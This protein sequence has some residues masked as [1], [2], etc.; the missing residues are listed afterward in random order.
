MNQTLVDEKTIARNAWRDSLQDGLYEL[1]SGVGLLFIALLLQSEAMG[2][3]VIVAI[4]MPALV[5]RLKERYTY[6]R[7]GYV[8]FPESSKNFGREMLAALGIAI[9]LIALLI[10]ATGGINESWGWNKWLPLLPA[11]LFQ[12][13]F[14]PLANRSGIKRYYLLAGLA[15]LLGVVFTLPTLPGRTD[16]LSLY[17][18]AIGTVL[19]IWGAILLITFLRRYPVQAEEAQNDE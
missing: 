3:V 5:K 9:A 12:A 2:F 10:V 1:T 17:L 19:A 8:G 15:L 11:L 14:L 13:A 18:F 4:F 6:P 7:L 16:N